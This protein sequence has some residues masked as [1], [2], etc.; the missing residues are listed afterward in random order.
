MSYLN[1]WLISMYQT[2]KSWDKRRTKL[3]WLN[4]PDF[5]SIKSSTTEMEFSTFSEACWVRVIGFIG[6][7]GSVRCLRIGRYFY[8][9]WPHP[10]KEMSFPMPINFQYLVLMVQKSGV[11]QLRLVVY[12]I[13]YRVSVTSQVVSRF[14]SIYVQ[15]PGCCWRKTSPT[16]LEV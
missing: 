5:R 8:N 3:N 9:L 15:F 7:F 6:V 13:I 2:R 11:H 16:G 10:W 1:H 4:R 12:P 14:S